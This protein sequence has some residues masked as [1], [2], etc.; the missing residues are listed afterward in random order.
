MDVLNVLKKHYTYAYIHQYIIHVCMY[1]VCESKVHIHVAIVHHVFVV[2]LLLL[3]LLLSLCS[4]WPIS[5]ERVPSSVACVSFVKCLF[6]TLFRCCSL[7]AR[8]CS[9]SVIVLRRSSC[10]GSAQDERF[11]VVAA[12]EANGADVSGE[13]KVR[14]VKLSRRE[15]GQRRAEVGV[16]TAR[17]SILP[18]SIL[19]R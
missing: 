9:L 10:E 6:G 19:R 15:P 7:Y 4:C 3:L 2:L 1:D 13:D 12:I 8:L 5:S 16:D 11:V 17:P 14:F 18:Q